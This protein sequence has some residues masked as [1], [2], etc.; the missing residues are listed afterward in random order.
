M[1]TTTLTLLTFI[2]GLFL[3][4]LLNVAII[5]L[6][7]EQRLLGWPRCTCTGEPLAWWQLLPLVGWGLQRGRASNGKPLHWIYPLVELL[8]ALV[9]ALLYSQY[10]FSTAFFYL[11]FVC[12]VLIVTG[13]ID[14]LYRY[15]YTFVILGAALLALLLSLVVPRLNVL[16]AG[17]GAL[18]AGVVFILLYL[19]A[20]LLF[21][22]KAAPF[23]MGDV[24][25][26]IFIGAALGLTRL[27]AALIYGVLLAGLVA[28]VIIVARRLLRQNSMPEY[29]SY[30]TYLCIGAIFYVVVWGLG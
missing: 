14:W 9:L 22:G 13:A 24:Y 12:I 11:A 8:T 28:A 21:P 27:G 19:L 3:G 16:N 30:G 25:L 17:L 26:G 20:K 4:T 5:R 1:M 7:R 18:V 6:P 15:I 2:V 29:I 10:G 23:G